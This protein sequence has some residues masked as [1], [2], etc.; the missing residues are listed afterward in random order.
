MQCWTA[1]L[2]RLSA[3]LISNYGTKTF[4]IATKTYTSEGVK[5]TTILTRGKLNWLCLRVT[6]GVSLKSQYSLSFLGATI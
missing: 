2:N 6:W 3:V 1:M 5:L 4:K